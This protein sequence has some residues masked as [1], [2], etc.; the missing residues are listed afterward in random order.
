MNLH[1]FMLQGQGCGHHVP[2]LRYEYSA[3]APYY[4]GTKHTGSLASYT[5]TFF[6]FGFPTAGFHV[7][8]MEL[9]RL[10]I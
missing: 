9:A 10:P 1:V 5:S 4:L 3:S 8:A 6:H 2:M 7:A